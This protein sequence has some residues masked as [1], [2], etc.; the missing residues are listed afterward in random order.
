MKDMVS[1]PG[2]QIQWVKAPDGRL[3]RVAV[4]SKPE[5]PPEPI[6]EKKIH[7]TANGLPLELTGKSSY[8]FVDIMDRIDFDLKKPA[9]VLVAVARNGYRT[10]FSAPIEEGDNLTIKWVNGTDELPPEPPAPEPPA[11]EPDSPESDA[12]KTDLLN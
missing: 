6:E 3:I 5:E 8:I 12:S 1:G 9:G 11:S 10:E 4:G 2:E 7:V